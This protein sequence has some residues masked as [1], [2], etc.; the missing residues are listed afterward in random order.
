MPLTD[1]D[2][3]LVRQSF[4]RLRDAKAHHR[5]PFGEMFYAKLFEK[6]PEARELFRSDLSEQGMR[7]LSTL[8]VIVES[9][10][11]PEAVSDTLARLGQGH[12]AYG[13]QTAHYGPMGEAL[14]EA[15]AA[16]LGDRYDAETDA[17]WARAYDEVAA[18]IQSATPAA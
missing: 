7:F 17:A 8:G 9:L 10:E 5:D 1:R 16:W 18:R 13:V 2:I 11:E 6:M 15:M 12:A 14:R 4:A 3:A